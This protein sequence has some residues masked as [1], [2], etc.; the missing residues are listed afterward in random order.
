MNIEFLNSLDSFGLNKWKKST[1]ES[2]SCS[3]ILAKISEV[4]FYELRC[5]V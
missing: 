3:D 4:R 2:K 5:P 1:E